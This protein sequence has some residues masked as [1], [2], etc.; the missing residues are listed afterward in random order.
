MNN[1]FNRVYLSSC[2]IGMTYI[3][4]DWL[5]DCAAGPSLI[6]ARIELF[7]ERYS[8]VPAI[9]I[10]VGTYSDEAEA[11]DRANEWL[12][13]HYKHEALMEDLAD[14]GPVRRTI[15]ERFRELTERWQRVWI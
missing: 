10:H 9:D 7:G 15:G 4:Y 13:N 11:I 2:E 6:H 12:W 3:E 1:R 5:I 14:C 8:D